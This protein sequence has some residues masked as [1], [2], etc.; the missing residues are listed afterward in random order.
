MGRGRALRAV[1]AASVVCRHVQHKIDSLRAISK[2]DKSPVTE[3]D[4]RADAVIIEGLKQI[5]ET[6][7]ILTEESAACGYPERKEWERFW[8]VRGSA[9]HKPIISLLPHVIPQRM[10]RYRPSGWQPPAKVTTVCLIPPYM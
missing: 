3:A 1:R 7:P 2:D 8:L 5:P 10:L 6:Y 4:R 9:W